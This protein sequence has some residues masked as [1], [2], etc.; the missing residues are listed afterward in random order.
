[1]V[2]AGM[3]ATTR[4]LLRKPPWSLSWL[5]AR[6]VVFGPAILVL[7][8]RLNEATVEME[9]LP[10]RD[11]LHTLHIDAFQLLAWGVAFFL[12]WQLGPT[13]RPNRV[14]IAAAITIC[15]IG[16]LSSAAGLVAL[17]IFLTVTALLG[18]RSAQRL[19][20]AT[21]FGA[22]FVQQAIIPILYDMLVPILT[23]FDTM[24]VGFFAELTIRG[25]TWQ[26]DTIS[27]PWDHSII[28]AGGCCSFR[29]VSLATLCWVAL[30]KLERPEWQPLDIGVLVIAAG[31]QIGL[32]VV[33]IYLMALSDNMY[34]Y[35]HTG[36]GAHIF[37]VTA[38]AGA[39]LICAFG[40]RYVSCSR[41]APRNGLAV[42]G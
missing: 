35:W 23:R 36:M 41:A 22:L 4:A 7:L 28:V 34:L 25:A 5:L 39:V 2:N 21:V 1:M 8:R 30:T 42:E 11:V 18:D 20:T 40:A 27:V 12:L 15:L 9:V 26:G 17:T 3:Q 10:D 38:S 37:A 31:F 24:L 29:N 32:N 19:A 33:R 6:V 16:G 13:R 14:D